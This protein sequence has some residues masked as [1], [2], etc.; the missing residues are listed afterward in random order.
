[1]VDKKFYTYYN[2]TNVG[3]V[4]TDQ[5]DVT[6]PTTDTV[7]AGD[8]VYFKRP[9]S[10]DGVLTISGQVFATNPTFEITINKGTTKCITYPW[11]ID[12]AI[13]D[14]GLYINSRRKGNGAT[15]LVDQL[16][17]WDS[18]AKKYV[19]YYDRT[20]VGWVKSTQEDLTVET[21]D[22]LKAGESIMFKRP[23]SANGVLT[24]PKPEGL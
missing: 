1:M 11:P 10:G 24:F 22:I 4:R 23:S 6:K 13:K 21:T 3:W 16:Q 19:I 20:N 5:T 7:K 8:G 14:F 17:K 9:S 18:A 15:A 12:F 2:R